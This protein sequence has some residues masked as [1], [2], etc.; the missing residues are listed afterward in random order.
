[1]TKG[2]AL[3]LLVLSTLP[4]SA[5]AAT[6]HGTVYEWSTLEPLRNAI[7]EIDTVPAQS[8]VAKDGVYS[9]EVPPGSYTIKASYYSGDVLEYYSEDN[10]TV[11]GE[12]EFVL[13][14]LLFPTLTIE[15]PFLEENISIEEIF[16]GR[17]AMEAG[18]LPA[19]SL[20]LSLGVIALFASLL[21]L[22]RR[23]RKTLPEA[24]PE[25]LSRLLSTLEKA[26]GRMTQKELRKQLGLS[27]AKVSLMLTDLEARGLVRRVKK[28]R[29]NV[30]IRIWR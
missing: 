28:G 10:V 11:V 2:L 21:Y 8:M 25:D 5:T 23:S 19:L 9:F 29:G 12:G 22:L 30:V 15:E 14:L 3:V 6:V 13:D 18:G 4:S 20:A 1:M 27:E 26:G 24:L 7:V 17:A 16:E